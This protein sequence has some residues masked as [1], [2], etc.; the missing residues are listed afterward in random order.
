MTSPSSYIIQGILA[1]L[2]EKQ[3]STGAVA[4]LMGRNKKEIKQILSGQLPLTVDDL[5]TFATKLEIQDADLQR[6]MPQLD[7][8][9]T[10]ALQQKVEDSQTLHLHDEDN[11]ATSDHDWTP[12]PVGVHSEQALRLGFSLGCN[13]FFVVNTKHLQ[14]SGVPEQTLKQFGDKLPIRLDADFF[15]HYRPEYFEEGLEIRLSF[16]AVYTCFFPWEAFEQITF[17]V[18]DDAPTATEPSTSKPTLRIVD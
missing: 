11:P 1:V 12:D 16:D 13:L 17:F 2:Q 6:F 4:K 5:S 8:V 14:N 7:N 3:M 9:Q 10:E 15:H 18:D